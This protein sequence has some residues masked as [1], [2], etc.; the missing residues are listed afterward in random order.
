MMLCMWRVAVSA[1]QLL[2]LLVGQQTPLAGLLMLIIALTPRAYIACQSANVSQLVAACMG[3]IAVELVSGRDRLGPLAVTI[4]AI[5]KFFTLPLGLVYIMRRRWQA[6]GLMILLT[7][8]I[9]G[10]T[11]ILGGLQPWRDYVALSHTFDR[12]WGFTIC[13]CSPKHSQEVG[14]RWTRGEKSF[15]SHLSSPSC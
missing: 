3:V 2:E 15:A 13:S 8:V 4:G 10:L 12:P 5:T 14:F 11:L 6:I 9:V 7:A 1:G